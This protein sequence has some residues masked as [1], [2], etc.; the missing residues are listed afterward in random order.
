[1]PMDS[2]TEENVD[3]LN[4]DRVNKENELECVKNT[5]IYQM[6]LNELELLKEQYLE[7][8]ENRERL[9]SGLDGAGG[10][11]SSKTKKKVVS[12]GPLKSKNN[13]L[14]VE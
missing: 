1:M 11:G 5:T 9:M 6:W 10:A 14:V 12:K 8:K 4:K 3:K 2:V 13:L 7:Y